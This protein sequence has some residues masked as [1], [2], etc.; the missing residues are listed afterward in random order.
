MATSPLVNKFPLA[1]NTELGKFPASFSAGGFVVQYTPKMRVFETS[2][3]LANSWLT[4]QSKLGFL[5]SC[6]P[7]HTQLSNGKGLTHSLEIIAKISI[8]L[9][10][11]GFLSFLTKSVTGLQD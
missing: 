9:N 6:F 8:H 10:H 1:A 11:F 4:H 7:N 2:A 3:L 5:F